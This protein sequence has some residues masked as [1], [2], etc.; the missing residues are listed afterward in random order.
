MSRVRPP[1]PNS[2]LATTVLEIRYPELDDAGAPATKRSMKSALRQHLP[3]TESLTEGR[4]ELAI[5]SPTPTS[6]H[7]RTFPRFFSRDRATALLVKEEALAL[8]TTS[9][10]GWEES[11]RPL[12]AV[13]LRALE[14]ACPPDGV[15]RIGLR[16]I[17]EI[18]VPGIDLV[19]GDWS[20]YIHSSLLA[21]ADPAFIP[22]S[23]Q[24]S[25]WQK[26]VQYRTAFDSTLTVRYGPQEGYAVDPQAATPRRNPPVPGTFFLLD[27]D[28]FWHPDEEV[29]EFKAEW[30]LDRCDDLHAPI[31]E[32][33]W[34]ATTDKLRDEVFDRRTEEAS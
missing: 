17:N 19:P 13:V 11:F 20:G 27:S 21:A 9:Y 26:I 29:P 25:L 10:G 1:F 22:E 15:L 5:G 7:Q 16:Y 8:E 4:I 12:I 30:I 32:V 3:L 18:R 24:P 31:R 14:K 6:V 2:P 34:I 33:F 28:S 23:L